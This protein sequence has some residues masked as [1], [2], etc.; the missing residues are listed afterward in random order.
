M[1][2]AFAAIL[3]G[4]LIVEFSCVF[5]LAVVQFAMTARDVLTDRQVVY[6]YVTCACVFALWFM[7]KIVLIALRDAGAIQ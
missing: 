4:V 3:M 1:I 7:G 6:L 2:E 5:M